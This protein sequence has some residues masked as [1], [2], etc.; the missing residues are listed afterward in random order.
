MTIKNKAKVDIKVLYS[1][2]FL[3][4]GLFYF[5]QNYFVQDF[6]KQLE[7]L[8]LWSSFVMKLFCKQD[9][10]KED[11]KKCYKPKLYFVFKPNLFL[12]KWLWKTKV[13]WSKFCVPFQ[14]AKTDKRCSFLNYP[15]A[16][17]FLV[18]SFKEIFE[19]FQKL[20]FIASANIFMK[21]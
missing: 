20:Q 16:G 9:T 18:L 17:R 7:I 3:Y 8:S 5:V 10:L 19:L 6:S 4:S 21:S 15:S 14:V 2:P 12:W 1:G 11:Y 13:V